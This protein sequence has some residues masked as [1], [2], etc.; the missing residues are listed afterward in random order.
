MAEPMNIDDAVAHVKRGRAVCFTGAGF[1]LGANNLAGGSFRTGRQFADEL[2]TACSLPDGLSLTDVSEEFATA[3]GDDALILK[4]QNEFSASAV[5][6]AHR[7]LASHGWLRTYTTNY[8]NVFEFAAAQEKRHVRSISL[9]DDIR[10]IP[11]QQPLCIHLNGF[12]GRL[13]RGTLW[14][15]IKLTDASYAAS[16]V[17][18]SL[19]STLFRQDLAKAKCVIFIGWSLYDLDIKRILSG[20]TE[21]QQKTFFIVGQ[22]A[23]DATIRRAK[24]YGTVLAENLDDFVARLDVAVVEDETED[25]F[26]SWRKVEAAGSSEA[27]TS[28]HVLD[29]LLLGAVDDSHLYNALHK[30][31]RYVLERRSAIRTLSALKAGSRGMVLYS[32]LGNGKSI[33][34]RT[35]MRR[36]LEEGFEPYEFIG[37]T[38]D[39]ILELDRLFAGKTKKLVIAIDNYPGHFDL[40]RHFALNAPH[41]ATLV[42]TARSSAHDVLVQD[43]AGI[44]AARG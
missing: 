16:S 44:L 26:Q 15:E 19:W 22:G 36:A 8:D 40:V 13:T 21:L 6:D 10:D 39:R 20:S 24:R 17:A 42:L 3:F 27:L 12:V 9:S 11:K 18:E 35:A 30:G 29:L 37:A 7:R 14:D 38:D 43:L 33:A 23:D 34:L 5:S 4:L 2:A 1:S 32:R 25:S 31:P 28:S 41:G